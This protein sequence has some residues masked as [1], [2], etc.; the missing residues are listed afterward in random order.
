MYKLKKYATVLLIFLVNV[1]IF[2]GC[3]VL[4]SNNNAFE[5]MKEKRATRITI[6]STRDNSYKFTVTDVGVAQE[7]YKI[8]SSAKEVDTKSPLEADYIFEIHEG[9]NEIHKFNYIAG[10]DK[11]DGANFYNDDKSYIVS[12]RLDNDIIKNFW[13]IRKP[14]DFQKIY[15]DTIYEAVDMYKKSKED[16]PKMGIN[17]NSDLEMS[18]F[19][20]STDLL[21]FEHR[22]NK[23][24][25]VTLVK[26]GDTEDFGIVVNINTEGYTLTKYKAIITFK[27]HAGER[28]TN[29]YAV[30]E[31]EKGEWKIQIYEKKPENF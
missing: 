29:Y 6:Q 31:Y 10:L 30:N 22:L 15:Y 14:I 3:S 16:N 1:V 27:G 17:M 18:K 24:S 7:I 2:T 8:L 23:M 9:P 19:I 4:K 21:N 25:D 5:F 11:N 28:E 20:L 12:K 26:N 13:N